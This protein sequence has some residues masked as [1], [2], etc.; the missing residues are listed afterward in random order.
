MSDKRWEEFRQDEQDLQDLQDE[1][2]ES[3]HEGLSI[4]FILLILSNH[5]SAAGDRDWR[6][7]VRRLDCQGA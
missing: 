2:G 1:R 5:L 6:I 3:D 4:L 7:D